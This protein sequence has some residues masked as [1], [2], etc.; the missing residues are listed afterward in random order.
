MGLLSGMAPE[1][2]LQAAC[3]VGACNVEAVGALSSIR[4]WPE[5]LERIAAGWARLPVALDLAQA[6]WSWDGRH[7]VWIGPMDNK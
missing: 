3:A 1:E 2:T 4:S 6:G 5:T 7:E